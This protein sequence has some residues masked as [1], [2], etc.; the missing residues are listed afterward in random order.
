[1][2]SAG[3]WYSVLR[4]TL[5][6]PDL[7]FGVLAGGFIA[8]SDGNSGIFQINAECV[9]QFRLTVSLALAYM[10]PTKYTGT[11]GMEDLGGLG[12]MARVAFSW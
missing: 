12:G 11:G 10:I 7:R 4:P 5:N 1:M 3:Y 6:M 8:G 9:L 2:L